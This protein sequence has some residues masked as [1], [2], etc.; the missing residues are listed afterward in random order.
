[1]KYCLDCD[2]SAS[3]VDDPS[4]QSRS[5]AAIHHHVET[6]HA[7]DSSDGPVRPTVPAV[8][9]ALLVRDLVPSSD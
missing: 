2:W 5:R 3:A 4:Q 9:G 1:M 8:S 7:I 6:G